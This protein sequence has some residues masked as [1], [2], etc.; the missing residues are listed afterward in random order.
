MKLSKLVEPSSVRFFARGS[1]HAAR[2][3]LHFL[4]I[5]AVRF[6]EDK[7]PQN[8]ASLAYTTLLSLVPLMA[9]SLT[10]VAAFPVSARVSEQVQAFVFENFMPDFGLMVQ[11]YLLQFSERATQLTGAGAA[12][13]LVVA[14]LLMSN[15]DQ[16]FGMIWKVR[17]RRSP[18]SRFMVYW[19]ILSLGPLLMGV[20]VAATSYLLSLPLFQS[21][22]EAAGPAQRLLRLAPILASTVAFT[23]LYLLVPNRRIPFRHALIGGV[24][25]AL[26]FEL[27]KHGFGLYLTRFPTHQAIYGALAA[28]PVFLIWLYIS[29]MITL[30]GG[31][32]VHLIGLHRGGDVS[33]REQADHDLL[34]AVDLLGELWQAQHLGKT[35]S[36]RRLLERRGEVGEDRLDGLL[37]ALQDARLVLCSDDG[38]WALAR[39]LHDVRLYD[40]F[41]SRPFG[42]PVARPAGEGRVHQEP[43][44]EL[45]ARIDEQLEE[46]MGLPLSELYRRRAGAGDP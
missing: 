30:L 36:T 16:A 26:L 35:L 4:R 6:G 7:G 13:L 34:L 27:A 32:L 37:T 21:G 8:A 11:E 1:G 39:D 9:V 23:L 20:S 19:S 3:A 10:L 46:A 17:R 40:L 45:L 44:S 42:L 2:E 18:L 5:L 22:A 12:F 25:A 38:G 33:S 28:V 31:E 14:V 15:I 24:V 41:R 29:W 43:L